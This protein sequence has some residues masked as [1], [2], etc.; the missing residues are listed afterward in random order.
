MC[1]WHTRRTFQGYNLISSGTSRHPP[2]QLSPPAKTA[3]TSISPDG[4]SPAPHPQAAPDLLSLTTDLFAFSAICWMEASRVSSSRSGFSHAA[5][6][7]LLLLQDG[8]PLCGRNSVCLRIPC[9]RLVSSF[10]PLRRHCQ[11]H[12][13]ARVCADLTLPLE[14]PGHGKGRPRIGPHRPALARL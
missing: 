13:C 6:V 7:C 12:L 11:G 9:G 4:S 1:N 8:V 14:L 3:N 2:V 10:R 5:R